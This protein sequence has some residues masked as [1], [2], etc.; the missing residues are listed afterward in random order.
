MVDGPLSPFNGQSH[1]SLGL[2]LS[3]ARIT[4]QARYKD[5]RYRHDPAVGFTHSDTP[6]SG[7]SGNSDIKALLRAVEADP[8]VLKL[9][10]TVDLLTKEMALLMG[11]FTA[12]V[13]STDLAAMAQIA[14]DSLVAVEARTWLQ[15]NLGV[16]LGLV[17]IATA[18]TVQGVVS[19]AMNALSSKYSSKS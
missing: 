10:P 7:N 9:A 14:V 12:A 16:E 15:R 17:D 5:A 11:P 8:D 4:S 18:G 13:K 6:S 19:L 3:G 2:G 1:L